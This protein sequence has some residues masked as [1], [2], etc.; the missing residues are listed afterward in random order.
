[1]KRTSCTPFVPSGSCT[2]TWARSSQPSGP[3]TS[4]MMPP[5]WVMPEAISSRTSPQMPS[6]LGA[7]KACSCTALSP[8]HDG[9]GDDRVARDLDP[10]LHALDTGHE[11]AAEVDPALAG[12]GYL[13]DVPGAVGP[14]RRRK[15][16]PA[17]PPRLVG[18][19]RASRS[20]TTCS[21]SPAASA[22][23]SAEPLFLRRPNTSLSFPVGNDRSVSIPTR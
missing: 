8:Q 1:M 18:V 2:G 5:C 23:S 13:G 3:S 4:S 12:L 20:S 14:R 21:A 7:A 10:Q 11:Q 19:R 16:H 15:V 6:F 22:A 9:G 17:G